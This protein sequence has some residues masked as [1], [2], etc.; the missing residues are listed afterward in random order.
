MKIALVARQ[1]AS[2]HV[3][4]LAGALASLGHDVT[5][6]AGQDGQL[7]GYARELAGSWRRNPPELVHAHHWTGVLAALA[8]AREVPVPVI[9]S[10][11]SFASAAH[12]HGL[13][14]DSQARRLEPGIARAA[15]SVIAST[16]EEAEELARL[17]VPGRNVACVPSGVDLRTFRPGPFSVRRKKEQKLI[18]I[19]S[20][21]EHRRL[22][23]LLRCLAELPGTDLVIAGGPAAADLEA[24][25]GYRVLAKLAA[26]LGI[27]ERVR[28]TGQVSDARLAGLLRSADLLVSAAS[29]EPEGTAA[30]QAM[31]CGVPVIATATGGYR[32]AVID[33]T[34]GML[35]PPERPAA[36]IRPV[37]ELLAAPM[38]RA[39][40]GIAGADRARSR[41]AWDRVA[42]ETAAWYERTLNQATTVLAA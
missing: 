11:G 5:A 18:A 15:A 8:A 35:V 32:D 34:T 2:A 24:D 40:F 37:R 12:R 16:K 13:A 31:A 28:F 33:G 14:A 42:A 6:T 3:T 39:A 7:P 23:L 27:T 20:L 1:S 17:G 29:Y 4:G 26:H 21:A 19:G 36:I 25:P 30:V 41:Y 22:D 9:A 38:R 10:F